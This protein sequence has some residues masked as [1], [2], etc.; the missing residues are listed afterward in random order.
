MIDCKCSFVATL[1][2]EDYAC[3][4]AQLVTRRAGPDIACTSEA[5]SQCCVQLYNQFKAVSLPAFGA[6]D[7]LLK[8][9]ASVYN[10]IQYGGLLALK[11]AVVMD[12]NTQ[13][14]KVD[15]IFD[16]V[17]HAEIKFKSIENI[18]FDQ[19]VENMKEFKIKRKKS[20]R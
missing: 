19:F 7:D 13:D 17:Q 10:K 1:I 20:K 14:R 8:T 3:E 11:K 9:P 16:L 2:T 6:E 18:P 12:D 5:G 15:N 4:K